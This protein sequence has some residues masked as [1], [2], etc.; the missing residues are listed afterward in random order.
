MIDFILKK[1]SENS[2]HYNLTFMKTVHKRS[3]DVVQEPGET[4]YTISLDWV[5]NRI[6]HMETTV[7][8]GNREVSLKEYMLEF[9]K[10]YKEVCK[11]LK[12]TL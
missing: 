4:I 7:R 8:L 9:H 11:L 2:P 1:V 5:K 12:K 3:G 10:T 6:A